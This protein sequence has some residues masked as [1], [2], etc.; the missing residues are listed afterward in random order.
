[1]DLDWICGPDVPD[2]FLDYCFARLPDLS[3][4]NNLGMDPERPVHRSDPDPSSVSVV[5]S[6]DPL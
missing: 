3:Y 2:P 1:M 5:W 6:T 4:T